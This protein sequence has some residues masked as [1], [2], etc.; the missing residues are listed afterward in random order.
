MGRV[1]DGRLRGA[2]SSLWRQDATGQKQTLHPHFPCLQ[3][4]WY[5]GGPAGDRTPRWASGQVGGQ[6]QCERNSAGWRRARERMLMWAAF[7]AF[8]CF[9]AAV[10]AAGTTDK[11]L[12]IV[13]PGQGTV[14]SI[15]ADGKLHTVSSVRRKCGSKRRRI[16]CAPAV[17]QQWWQ[18]VSY[19]C[20][21]LVRDNLSH[22]RMRQPSQ[23]VSHTVSLPSL[24]YRPRSPWLPTPKVLLLASTRTVS[25]KRKLNTGY[26]N[27]R[28]SVSRH[29]YAPHP[30][31]S[32]LANKSMQRPWLLP[33]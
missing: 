30:Q 15:D 16:L 29:F 10:A 18:W 14:A 21:R 2:V 31:V 22:L 8:P 3:W 20:E 13:K 33:R 17:I 27:M 1:Q 11:Y 23:F 7:A 32:S 5:L 9:P 26:H 4:D 19:R 6:R 28:L 24:H 12:S 25:S